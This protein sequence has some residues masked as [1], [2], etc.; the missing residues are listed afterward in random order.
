MVIVCVAHQSVWWVRESSGWRGEGGSDARLSGLLAD[1][2]AGG[3]TGACRRAPLR[4]AVLAQL[5]HYC[6][7]LLATPL[8]QPAPAAAPAPAPAPAHHQQ[9]A[10]VPIPTAL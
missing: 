2:L 7:K 3:G 6:R 10:S 1:V 9:P 8:P 4:R 5:L